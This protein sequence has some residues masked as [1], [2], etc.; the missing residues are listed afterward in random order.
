MPIHG[1]T[2]VDVA[3]D[4]YLERLRSAARPSPTAQQINNAGVAAVPKPATE[5]PPPPPPLPVHTSRTIAA[6]PGFAVGRPPALPTPDKTVYV[7]LNRPDGLTHLDW[8]DLCLR[9]DLCF[10]DQ[11]IV[12]RAGTPVDTAEPMTLWVLLVPVDRILVVQAKLLEALA[13]CSRHARI[14]WA[15]ATPRVIG[16]PA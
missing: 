3:S 5:V 1:S 14:I 11:W 10:S 4:G 8:R 15:E 12:Q 9:V 2:R 7:S 16:R 13:T 6:A